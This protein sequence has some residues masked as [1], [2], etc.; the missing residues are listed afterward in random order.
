LEHCK[1]E[2]GLGRREDGVWFTEFGSYMLICPWF[3]DKCNDPA[4]FA[5]SSR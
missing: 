4:E 5:H 3:S 1:K 2:V